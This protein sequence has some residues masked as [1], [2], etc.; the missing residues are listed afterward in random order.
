MSISTGFTAEQLA[1]LPRGT[2]RH[3][4]VRG[5]L[6]TMAPAGYEHGRCGGALAWRLGQFVSER[7]LGVVTLAETGF[8]L[9]RD[10]DTVRAP[11]IAFVAA[12]RSASI[13]PTTRYVVGPPDLAVE[14]LSPDDTVKHL[15]EK[16]GDWLAGGAQEVW[17]VNLWRRT[18]AIHRGPKDVR[19]LTHGDALESPL[20]PGFRCPLADLFA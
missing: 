11:D 12:A 19:L 15:E 18:I 9:E 17:V 3:Q 20:L 4:L 2:Q 5:E 10:P 6:C 13:D 1:Q 8:L 7:R 14:V 16:V